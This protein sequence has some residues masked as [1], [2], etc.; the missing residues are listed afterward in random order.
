MHEIDPKTIETLSKF[1]VSEHI[2]IFSHCAHPVI[3][4]DGTIVNVGLAASFMGMNYV[5][6][7]FPG[8]E[9]YQIKIKVENIF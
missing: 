8:L 3:L 4:H 9:K 2:P 7:E 1:N 5:V 6:F